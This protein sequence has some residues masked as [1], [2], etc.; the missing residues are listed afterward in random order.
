[1]ASSIETVK[2]LSAALETCPSAVAL[3]VLVDGQSLEPGFHVTE[4]SKAEVKSLDC[5]GRQLAWSEAAIQVLDS[6]TGRPMTIG[7]L[8][9]ILTKAQGALEGLAGLPLMVDADPG[10]VG[11][12][13]YTIAAIQPEADTVTV[14]LTP[15]YATCKPVVE[16]EKA[17]LPSCR[18]VA[19]CA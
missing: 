2:D 3:R 8:R 14:S 16:A 13:R 7:T 1:M 10:G 19:C 5:G 18:S 4:V 11:I 17:G 15:Q 6:G 9:G 12:R